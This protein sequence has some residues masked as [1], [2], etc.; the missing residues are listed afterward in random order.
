ML[1]ITET[2]AKRGYVTRKGKTFQ[3]STIKSVLSNR[4]FYEGKYKYGKD[5]DWVDGV[6]EPILK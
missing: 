6:H 4:P 1:G 3:V 5:M 2:L